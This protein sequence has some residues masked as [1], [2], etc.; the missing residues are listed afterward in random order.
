MRLSLG[1]LALPIFAAFLIAP[2]RAQPPSTTPTVCG[3]AV[4]SCVFKA[5]Q[6]NIIQIYVTPSASGYLMVFNRATEPT[7]GA[8]TAGTA[9]NNMTDCLAVPAGAT[10]SMQVSMPMWQYTTGVVAAFSSTFCDTLTLSANAF[11][12]GYAQ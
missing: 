12:K 11:I 4:S 3:S 6:G 1:F 5:S 7:N 8:T 2:A 10:V 9:A